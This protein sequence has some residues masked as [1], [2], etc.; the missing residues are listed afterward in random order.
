MSAKASTRTKR[1]PA[2]HVGGGAGPLI[3]VAAAAVIFVGALLWEILGPQGRLTA[4]TGRPSSP[5]AHAQADPPPGVTGEEPGLFLETNWSHL[6]PGRP[7]ER[8]IGAEQRGLRLA[9]QP[10]IEDLD[11]DLHGILFA[12]AREGAMDGLEAARAE[13]PDRAGAPDQAEAPGQGSDTGCDG[14]KPA[15]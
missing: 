9:G 2:I 4:P 7:H 12:E 10:H 11:A 5:V 14:S 1:A 15:D 6:A 8:A 3:A 13:A